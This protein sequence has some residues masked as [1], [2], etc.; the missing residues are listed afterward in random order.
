LRGDPEKH[1]SKV[2]FVE[3]WAFV[4]ILSFSSISSA[5][6]RRASE[7]KHWD[8]GTILRSVGVWNLRNEESDPIEWGLKVSEF[9]NGWWKKS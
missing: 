3:I 4:D 9:G 5:G 6:S 7:G 2:E 1:C 8:S